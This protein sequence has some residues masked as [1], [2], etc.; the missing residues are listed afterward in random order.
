MAFAIS[1]ATVLLPQEECPSMA[2]MMFLSG[3]IVC[4][5]FL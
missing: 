2:I 5:V 4:G 1:L 3:F